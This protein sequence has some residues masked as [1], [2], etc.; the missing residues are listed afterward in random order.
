MTRII[1]ELYR[2][3]NNSQY[4]AFVVALQLEP[5]TFDINVTPDKRTVLLHEE[6]TLL[7]CIK[8]GRDED[9]PCDRITAAAHELGPSGCPVSA[10]SMHV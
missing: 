1:N 2:Q 5:G 6:A 9:G 7:E 3:Y 4:P 8:V 10:V